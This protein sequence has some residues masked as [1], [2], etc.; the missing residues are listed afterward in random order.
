MLTLKNNLGDIIKLT[1]FT[2][3]YF[4]LSFLTVPSNLTGYMLSLYI[5]VR[6]LK[7][8]LVNNTENVLV[9]E[10]RINN[11]ETLKERVF[12]TNAGRVFILVC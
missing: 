7:L 4:P 9:K 10:L 5:L 12:K 8:H 6:K 2:D 1:T 11:F 3:L